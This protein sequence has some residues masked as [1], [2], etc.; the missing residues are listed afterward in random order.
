MRLEDPGRHDQGSDNGEQD[1]SHGGPGSQLGLAG[2]RGRGHS[3]PPT[4]LAGFG[5]Y[6]AA[7][8]LLFL[9]RGVRRATV[10]GRTITLWTA[11]GVVLVALMIGVLG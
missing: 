11:V 1:R 10:H 7:R 5:A 4:V 3:G 2:R 6:V 8:Q 9:P